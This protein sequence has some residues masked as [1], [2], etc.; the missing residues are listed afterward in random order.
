VVE[1]L[2]RSPGDPIEALTPDQFPLAAAV[3]HGRGTR[4]AREWS[5]ACRG[6]SRAGRALP[7]AEQTAL[8]AL[9]ACSDGSR[10]EADG[11]RLYDV[12]DYGKALGYRACPTHLM[13]R[14]AG[15]RRALTALRRR[16]DADGRRRRF[17]SRLVLAP[18]HQVVRRAAR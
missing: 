7:P 2:R 8:V 6:R 18:A 13:C 14:V 15:S 12:K 4:Q 5:R 17:Q 16:S 9:P 10:A 3:A 1:R 11:T